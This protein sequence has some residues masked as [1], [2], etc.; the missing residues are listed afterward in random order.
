MALDRTI[1]EIETVFR[2]NRFPIYDD[3]FMPDAVDYLST[4]V[5]DER[6]S[7]KQISY[8]AASLGQIELLKLMKPIG[9]WRMMSA[10]EHER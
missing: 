6:S 5:K 8:S 4:V 9:A 10:I 3:D 7:L 1:G 2:Q